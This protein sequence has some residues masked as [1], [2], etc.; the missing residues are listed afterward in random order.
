MTE[1]TEVDF[2]LRSFHGS[3]VLVSVSEI[4]DGDDGLAADVEDAIRDTFHD[5]DDVELTTRPRR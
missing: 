4:S 2:D 5:R 3:R 1:P